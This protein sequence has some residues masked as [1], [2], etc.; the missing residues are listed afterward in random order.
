MP[1]AAGVDGGVLDHILAALGV[2]V[3]LNRSFGC[4]PEGKHSLT[5][6]NRARS[7]AKINLA[8]KFKARFLALGSVQDSRLVQLGCSASARH[9][10]L[11]Q[12]IPSPPPERPIIIKAGNAIRTASKRDGPEKLF[13]HQLISRIG[14]ADRRVGSY[15]GST[16]EGYGIVTQQFQSCS[17]LS[18]CLA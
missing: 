16:V 6:L 12:P 17:R 7:S 15:T 8:K 18:R 3:V 1:A 10:F 5:K 14:P 13:S 2:N 11:Q 4:F 9:Q